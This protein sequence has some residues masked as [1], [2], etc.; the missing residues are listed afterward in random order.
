MVLNTKTNI[1]V[2]LYR[3]SKLIYGELVDVEKFN[4]SAPI[5]L[6]KRVE[7]PIYDFET[8]KSCGLRVD[9]NFGIDLTI[10]NGNFKKGERSLHPDT[11]SLIME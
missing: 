3:K 7:I 1:K 11:Y 9:L 5:F 4:K 6:N 10:S 2:A 8:Y